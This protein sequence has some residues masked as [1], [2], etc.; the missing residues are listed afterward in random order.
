MGSQYRHRRTSDPTV[1]FPQLEPGEISVNTAN[2]QLAVGDANGATIGQ[3]IVLLGVRLF[4]QRSQYPT[5]DLMVRAGVIYRA[6]VDVDPGPFD[7]AKWEAISGALNPAYVQKAGD[8]MTGALTLSGDPTANLHAVTKQYSDT[9][10]AKAGGIMT[11]NLVLAGDPSAPAMAATKSYVDAA[12]AAKAAVYISDTPPSGVPDNSLWW[13][14]DTGLLFVRYNDGDSTQWV[15]AMP[16]TDTASFVQKAGDVMTG[17]LTLSGDPTAL[18][19]AATK[20]YVDAGD[21]ATLTSANNNMNA[22]A[23]RYD[24]A[25][26]LNATQQAQGRSNIGAQFSLAPLSTFLAANVN[27]PA[28]V[29]TDA[30]SL[31]VGAG[32][33]SLV[34]A[35]VSMKDNAGVAPMSVR[36]TDGTTVFG[37]SGVIY[38]AAGAASRCQGIVV[39]FV[40]NPVGGVI[41]LQ[42]IAMSSSTSGVVVANDA[43][44]GKDTQMVA[45]KIA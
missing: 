32:T 8:T 29:W 21:T 6:L 43:G 19:H 3:P 31:N 35:A 34:I 11:G 5:G 13:E 15:L 20:Q 12:V 22:R 16:V 36:L 26:G 2:R 40:T 7:G 14:S 44:Q 17:L 37:C 18:L 23:V 33:T 45:L 27:L 9:K 39:A 42:A 24:A 25:Q 1:A 4:D 38:N 30:M 41:K 10:L 28:N